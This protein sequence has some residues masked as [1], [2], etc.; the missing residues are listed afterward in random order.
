MSYII[1]PMKK[2]E[3]IEI[4][5]W[6]YEEPYSFYNM[7]GSQEVIEELLDGSY[8]TVKKENEEIF[9]YFC[10]GI[11]AQ[12]PEG[13]KYN[14]YREKDKIDIGLGMKPE[15]TG[16]GKGI[17]FIRK[18]LEFAKKKY[19]TSKIRLTVAIFNKRAIKTYENVGF[20]KDNTFEI[21]RGNN[22]VKFITMKYRY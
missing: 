9:G 20:E 22:I 16:Q 15:L 12:V 18:G 1:R 17:E 4:S 7:G 3:A 6:E 14:V 2:D 19:P 11:S 21:K 13:N 8:Y 10:F 5:K